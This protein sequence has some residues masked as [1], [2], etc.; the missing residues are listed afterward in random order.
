[1]KNG[2]RV[3]IVIIPPIVVLMVIF[4]FNGFFWRFNN[5]EGEA[6]FIEIKVP[7]E[8]R[9]LESYFD[10]I[11]LVKSSGRNTLNL[12]GWVFRK[13]VS[14]VK[15]M[16][17]LVLR[18]PEET[19]VFIIENANNSRP[20]VTKRYGIEK[21]IV[22]HGFNL[23]LPVYKIKDNQYQMGFI[24]KDETG[25]YYSNSTRSV[26][27]SNGEVEIIKHTP[28]RSSQQVSIS[29][30]K[31]ASEIKAWIDKVEIVDNFLTIVGW[32]FLPGE[33]PESQIA[34]ILLKNGEKEY[35]YTVFAQERKDITKAFGQYGFNLDSAGFTS[36]IAVDLLEAGK[37]QIGVYITN[38]DK[39]GGVYLNK[40]MDVKK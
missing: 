24:I 39:K 21:G 14:D 13:N 17:Y 6:K 34:Y 30:Q 26:K 27:L 40:F 12:T 19:H 23:I 33:D 9:Q 35:V 8:G 20:D 1:M 32:G 18:S 7:Q 22:N 5:V 16:V 31:S 38:K 29:V 28:V 11:D 2:L 36:K 4:L 37:Y 3:A 25:I 10:K 15:R